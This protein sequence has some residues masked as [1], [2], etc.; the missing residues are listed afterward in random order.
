[1]WQTIE[2][3]HLLVFPNHYLSFQLVAGL[4][5]VKVLAFAPAVT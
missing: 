1:V 5:L 4:R 3:I 2:R